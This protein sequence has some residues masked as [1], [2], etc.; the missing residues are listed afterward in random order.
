MAELVL[1]TVADAAAALDH[2][3]SAIRA[4]E[5]AQCL[6]I[7]RLCDLHEVDET[8]LVEGCERWVPGGADGT[9]LIGEFVTAHISTLL[10][11]GIGSAFRS[12]N[13]VLNLRHRHPTLWRLV[14]A[15]DIRP[16]EGFLVA[17]AAVAAKLDAAACERFDRM[18]ATALSLQPWGRVKG[19]VEKWLLLADPEQA[20]ANAQAAGRRRDVTLGR[21]KDGHISLWGQLDAADGLALDEALNLLA[22]TVD[23][24]TIDERRATALGL[25]A[26][27]TLGQSPLPDPGEGQTPQRRK[28]DLIVRL[29]HT[30]IA[31]ING[32]GH[33]LLSQLPSI[34]TGCTVRV[35]PI[36][37]GSDLLAVDGYHVP[38]TMRTVLNER[39]PVDVF[40]FGTRPADT[41]QADHTIPYTPGVEGQTHLGNLGPLSSFTHRL[42]THGGWH[43]E[44]P[45]PGH[46]VWRSPLGYEYAVTAAGTILIRRPPPPEHHWWHQEPPDD[47]PVDDVAPPDGAT[48]AGARPDPGPRQQP[49]PHVA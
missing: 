43:L 36:V 16:F 31:T 30:G 39:N 20:A 25:M 35:R 42:K 10:G 40:P 24:H 44:Q 27:Q 19:Q 47:R 21:I 4:G 33:V 14:I 18:C 48:R 17:D 7:A 41:C 5:V 26:R 23:G 6:A 8:V 9:P 2:A 3:T 49:L 1:K 11:A 15:G 46:Y 29:D 38:D 45:S 37:I 34:L 13:R 22:D 12:I 32:W 28:V